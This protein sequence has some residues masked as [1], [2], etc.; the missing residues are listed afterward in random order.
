MAFAERAAVHATNLANVETTRTPEGGPYVAMEAALVTDI[1]GGGGRGVRL[2]AAPSA[3]PPLRRFDPGHPHADADGWV[4]LP[5]VDVTRETALLAV[6]RR[7]YEANIA[8][9]KAVSS[10]SSAALEIGR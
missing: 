4:L 6:A 3:E 8:A 7:A 2:L 9:A 10:M 5:A 1:A